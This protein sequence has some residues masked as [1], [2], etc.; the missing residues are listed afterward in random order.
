MSPENSMHKE[1]T[2][3]ELYLD[4]MADELWHIWLKRVDARGYP[5]GSQSL[6]ATLEWLRQPGMAFAAP[7]QLKIT[8]LK[9]SFLLVLRYIG[10]IFS[11]CTR[12]PYQESTTNQWFN[13][14]DEH[15]LRE[16]PVKAIN[17]E[18]DAASDASKK[19]ST[20]F[21]EVDNFIKSLSDGEHEILFHGTSHEC[22]L[23]IVQSIDVKLGKERQDFSDGDGF[24]L[25]DSFDDARK[26]P[27]S[28]GH[29]NTAVLV[30]RVRKT[31][32][33]GE[34]KISL[35][36][37]DDKKKWQEV[38]SQFRSGRPDRKFLKDIRK[39]EFI[40]GP[41]ASMSRKNPNHNYPSPKE[42]SYQLCVRKDKCAELFNQSLH[43]V[44]FFER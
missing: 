5:L 22:A 20:P 2:M 12:F 17:I 36:L 28:R 6:L 32:L 19:C 8:S 37:R 26:W 43:S 42:D 10:N 9:T 4:A 23:D 13:L 18:G 38:V 11:K 34:N 30:Y 31:E 27:K 21:H 40:E 35:D 39:Y 3:A 15:G 24:Y 16:E 44:V 41:M 7:S 29:S 14:P 25:G 33:R 1:R